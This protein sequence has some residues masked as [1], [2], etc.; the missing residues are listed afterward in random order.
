[1]TIKLKFNYC[2]LK[3]KRFI[4]LVY[5]VL[6]K[7]TNSV[8][9]INSS[10]NDDQMM[11]KFIYFVVWLELKPGDFVSHLLFHMK[12]CLNFFSPSS[13]F[14]LL[15]L[16]SFNITSLVYRENVQ[17]ECEAESFWCDFDHL[18]GDTSSMVIC[19]NR[20]L[21]LGS[22]KFS[23]VWCH[24]VMQCSVMQYNAMQCNATQCNVM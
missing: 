23:S 14:L 7:N 20:I 19:I 18:G 6:Q 1:M 4:N 13:P 3:V 22:Y 15:L 8:N 21:L 12:K 9:S 5:W 10:G 17:F 16:L 24:A 2:W 11:I